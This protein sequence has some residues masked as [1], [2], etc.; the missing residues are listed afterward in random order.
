MNS[1]HETRCPLASQGRTASRCIESTNS[2]LLGITD[3][4]IGHPRCN[5]DTMGHDTGVTV[6]PGTQIQEADL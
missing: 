2:I 6:I 3:T 5:K 4:A 1:H